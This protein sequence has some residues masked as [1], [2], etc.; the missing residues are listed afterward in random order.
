MPKEVPRKQVLLHP[1]TW[2]EELSRT[3]FVSVLPWPLYRHT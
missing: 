1:D 2:T 3:P